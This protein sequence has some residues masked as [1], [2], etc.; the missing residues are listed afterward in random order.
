MRN[1]LEL[2]DARASKADEFERMQSAEVF[3]RNAG[4]LRRWVSSNHFSGVAF[5]LFSLPAEVFLLIRPAVA[6]NIHYP[7]DQSAAITAPVPEEIK[8]RRSITSNAIISLLANNT[9]GF[10]EKNWPLWFS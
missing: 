10:I 6:N 7:N 1:I 2:F 9:S 8:L 5:R 4:N 3:F